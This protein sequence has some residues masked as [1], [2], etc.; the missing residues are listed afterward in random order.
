[1]KTRKPD[2]YFKQYY[3]R[4]PAREIKTKELKGGAAVIRRFRARRISFQPDHC[5][6]MQQNLQ[7]ISA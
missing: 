2:N 5:A 7:A 4:L 3:Q 1:V 6:G